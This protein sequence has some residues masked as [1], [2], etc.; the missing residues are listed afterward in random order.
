MLL[1]FAFSPDGKTLASASYD[2]TVRLW[3][4]GT[5]N[6][7]AVFTEDTMAIHTL[8]FSPDGN[9]LASGAGNGTIL[10]WNPQH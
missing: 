2:S 6:Q 10:L 8:T 9:I 3:D 7:K 4:I 1:V 5:N